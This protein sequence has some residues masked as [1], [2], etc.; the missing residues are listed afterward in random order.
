MANWR[1]KT[2]EKIREKSI[3]RTKAT[4][5][6]NDKKHGKIVTFKTKS[7]ESEYTIECFNLYSSKYSVLNIIVNKN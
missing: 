2:L 6:L 7:E 4:I 3:K 1:K 5:I